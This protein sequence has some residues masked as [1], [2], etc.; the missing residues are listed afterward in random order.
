MPSTRRD[1]LSPQEAR[2]ALYLDF[3]GRKSQPP[4]LLGLARRPGRNLG[5]GE[6]PHVWQLVL[7]PLFAPLASGTDLGRASLPAAIER[8]VTRAETEERLIVAWSEH[9]L[10]VV[11]DYCPPALAARFER[12]FVNARAVALH[13]IN[14]CHRDWRPTEQR[15]ADYLALIGYVVP[16]EAGPGRVGETLE[17]I[18]NALAK[19]RGLA[20]LTPNQLQRW[21]QLREHNAHDC[22]GMRQVCLRATKELEARVLAA[23]RSSR[24]IH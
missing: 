3:E 1:H 6:L 8:I 14:A 5:P 22:A 9:E 12:R 13:W 2:Q 19:G 24:L 17:I 15:L 21:A 20:G 7:D 4:V 18:S 10:T 23:A 16:A 11:R